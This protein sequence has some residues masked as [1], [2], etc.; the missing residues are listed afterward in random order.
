MGQ[1]FRFQFSNTSASSGWFHWLSTNEVGGEVENQIL[2]DSG[3]CVY[4][5][6]P[7]PDSTH[8]DKSENHHP[9]SLN[10]RP[11]G[12]G[13]RI[14]A[15]GGSESGVC[16]WPRS[17]RFWLGKH[18]GFESIQ[19]PGSGHSGGVVV[20][21]HGSEPE[22]GGVLQVLYGDPF[23]VRRWVPQN[24]GSFGAATQVIGSGMMLFGVQTGISI[25]PSDSVFAGP[26][27]YTPPASGNGFGEP[28]WSLA[29]V[30]EAPGDGV[31]NGWP[32]AD[33]AFALRNL[34]RVNGSPGQPLVA[35]VVASNPDVVS[36]TA[37]VTIDASEAPPD[38]S[39]SLDPPAGT[40]LSIGPG[41]AIP[42][43]VTIQPTASDTFGAVHIVQ[44]FVDGLP[45][46]ECPAFLGG[47]TFQV[48]VPVISA[49]GDHEDAILWLEPANPNPFRE[50]LT[51]SYRASGR[52]V[53]V[54]VYD[55]RGRLVRTLFEGETEGL[56]TAFWDGRSDIGGVVPSGVYFLR[57]Q[58]PHGTLTRRLIRLR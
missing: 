24:P 15:P 6:D 38:W 23:L 25:P 43:E 7:H 40:P 17:E 30:Y 19:I 21:N 36:R 44:D 55:V 35:H 16:N 56:R 41:G 39:I 13:Y 54:A 29:A 33:N 52:S 5:G 57:L 9:D 50:T 45:A 28:F 20:T 8:V 49:A 51:L 14:H 1:T 53:L 46:F 48:A 58:S 3:Y 4:P 34:W 47:A 12:L 27:T 37:V 2:P 31:D 32:S 42:I 11:D 18:L 22:T 10:A 26:F